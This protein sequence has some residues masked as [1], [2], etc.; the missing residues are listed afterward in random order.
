MGGRRKE[1]LKLY[2]LHYVRVGSPFQRLYFF[3]QAVICLGIL[4][5]ISSSSYY[6]DARTNLLVHGHVSR[7][8][9]T[10]TSWTVRQMED[11]YAYAFPKKKRKYRFSNPSLHSKINEVMALIIVLERRRFYR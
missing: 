9:Y 3:Y 5:H 7:G 4:V 1:K 6:R 10:V 11:L 8:G 2:L